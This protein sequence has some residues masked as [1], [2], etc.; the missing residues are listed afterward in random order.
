[1]IPDT[2]NSLTTKTF[3]ES[4]PSQSFL[5]I[6]KLYFLMMQKKL[7]IEGPGPKSV[8]E[9]STLNI[10]TKKIGSASPPASRGSRARSK[11]SLG[12]KGSVDLTSSNIQ[13]LGLSGI[14]LSQTSPGLQS[15]GSIK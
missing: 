11:K 3:C 9:F 5:D 10:Q 4:Q 14:V 12:S 6:D 1:M 2:V 15:K 13:K 8:D 7:Q